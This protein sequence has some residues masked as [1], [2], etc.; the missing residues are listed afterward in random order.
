M[1]SKYQIGHIGLRISRVGNAG[2]LLAALGWR[3]D[4][5]Q[6]NNRDA[7]GAVIP[8]KTRED[9][10]A[11]DWSRLST[12]GM[13]AVAVWISDAQWGANSGMTTAQWRAR[14]EIV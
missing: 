12:L 5:A 6:L 8:N 3:Q 2:R 11:F 9:F 7:F 13:E 10:A 1:K 4:H 14:K